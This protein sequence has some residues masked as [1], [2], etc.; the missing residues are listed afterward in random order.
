MAAGDHGQLG[1]RQRGFASIQLPEVPV[2]VPHTIDQPGRS[3]THLMNKC[4]SE[5]ILG[6][7]DNSGRVMKR[8]CLLCRTDDSAYLQQTVYYLVYLA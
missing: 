3:V 2:A 5:T 1:M 4:V 6:R 8:K 7:G